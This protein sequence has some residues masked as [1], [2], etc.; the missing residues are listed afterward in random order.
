MKFTGK[1]VVVTGA[2]RGL[3]RAFAL[4]FAAGGAKV[5][6]TDINDCTDTVA[7]IEAAGGTATSIRGDISKMEDM[8]ALADTA[9]GRFGPASVLVNNAALYGPLGGGR[10]DRLSE[11]SWDACMAVNVKG[12]WNA[13]KAFV[14]QMRQVGSG[15]IVNVSSL[16]ATYGL[17][18]ALHY[19]V[20]K[21]AVIGL[22]RGLARE[23]GPENIRANAIAPSAV[24]TEGTAEFMGDKHDK[25]VA[26]I[27]AG[28]SIKRNLV[29]G[30]L[31][32]TVLFLASDDAA[33][34]TGQTIAVDGGTVF[35]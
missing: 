33:F 5:V 24:L 19:T 4:G 8:L 28:Q 16:A 10:F 35:L 21:A 23:L 32:G 1:T 7:E 29:A 12:L 20:S 25:A 11:E 17:A 18:Y 30:D 6:A 34:V 9:A 13:A 15:S 22:T 31:V 3:G 27:A 26:L 2:A 14:P